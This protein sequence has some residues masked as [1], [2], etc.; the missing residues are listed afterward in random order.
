MFEA[1]HGSAPRMVT[2]GRVQYANP[3]SVMRAA[4]MMLAHIGFVREAGLF[5]RALDIC[6]ISEKR[7]IITGRDTGCTCGEFAAYVME[8]CKRLA[9]EYK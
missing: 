7:I 8:T 4:A 6:T 5:T 1:I 2:E 3:A 9:E